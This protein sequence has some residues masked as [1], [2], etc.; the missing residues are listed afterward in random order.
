MD[1]AQINECSVLYE[2]LCITARETSL[3]QAGVS[4]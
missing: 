4:V 1:T 2:Y 3:L